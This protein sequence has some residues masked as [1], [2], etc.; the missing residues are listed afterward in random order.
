YPGAVDVVIGAGAQV[1]GISL[2]ALSSDGDNRYGQY[3]EVGRLF[4]EWQAHT[5]GMLEFSPLHNL[6]RY[7]W[8]KFTSG[9]GSDSSALAWPLHAIGDAVAPQHVVGS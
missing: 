4:P 2:N 7:G 3:D 8:E 5:V 9:G 6:A 1:A